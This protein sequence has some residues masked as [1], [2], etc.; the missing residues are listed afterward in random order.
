M[1]TAEAAPAPVKVEPKPIT[2]I[3][4]SEQILFTTVMPEF[5]PYM[6]A[7]LALSS[8]VADIPRSAK[9]VSGEVPVRSDASALA[10][11]VKGLV[12]SDDQRRLRPPLPSGVKRHMQFIVSEMNKPCPGTDVPQEYRVLETPRHRESAHTLVELAVA[13]G[14]KNM[15]DGAIK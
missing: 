11:A 14:F 1:A 2:E 5:L 8:F 3:E 9:P 12:S 7:K 15:P 10:R 13:H 6:Q 4:S